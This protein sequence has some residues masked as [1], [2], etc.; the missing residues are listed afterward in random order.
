[1]DYAIRRV[2]VDVAFPIY[3]SSTVLCG[4]DY[5]EIHSDA[6]CLGYEE[7]KM[8]ITPKNTIDSLRS[9]NPETDY[10]ALRS[11]SMGL[12]KTQLEQLYEIMPTL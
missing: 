6:Y 3:S 12:S 10:A 5:I 8:V 2:T 11:W 7:E 1:M 4:M 9:N